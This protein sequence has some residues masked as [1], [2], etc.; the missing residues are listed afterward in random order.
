[1]KPTQTSRSEREP[2]RQPAPMRR[3]PECLLTTLH[4]ERALSNALVQ[5]LAE[6]MPHIA[7]TLDADRARPDVVW[8]CG[9][10]AGAEDMVAELRGQHPAALLVVTGRGPTERWAAS[11]REAGADY[12]CGW[13]VPVAE[14]ARILQMDRRAASQP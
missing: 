11:V 14:L 1:M 10:E 2:G 4:P 8:V 13:P 12:T 9:Y 3:R 7:F 5:H 6:E